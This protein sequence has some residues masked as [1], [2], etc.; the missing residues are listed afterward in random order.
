MT[1]HY[2]SDFQF[3]LMN[4]CKRR[5]L[6]FDGPWHFSAY[7]DLEFYY[8]LDLKFE[9]GLLWY[10]GADI[11]GVRLWGCE[12]FQNIYFFQVGYGFFCS[13]SALTIPQQQSIYIQLR[14]G[15]SEPSFNPILQ[16]LFDHFAKADCSFR[17]IC[18]SLM[19]LS[20]IGGFR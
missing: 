7:N 3:W 8:C 16:L 10:L 12:A 19:I 11:W 18:C 2:D 20:A 17:P 4:Y 13:S 9:P 6:T 1:T 15:K 5:L 14:D